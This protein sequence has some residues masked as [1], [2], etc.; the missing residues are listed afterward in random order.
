MRSVPPGVASTVRVRVQ[1]ISRG[2]AYG[3]PVIA[4]VRVLNVYRG[5]KPQWTDGKLAFYLLYVAPLP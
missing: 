3:A 5:A 2:D 1:A 4:T